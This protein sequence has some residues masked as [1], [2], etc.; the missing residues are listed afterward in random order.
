M[1]NIIISILLLLPLSCFACRVS[2]YGNTEI[3]KKANAV[4]EGLVV[5]VEL[6]YYQEHLKAKY[7]TEDYEA[8]GFPVLIMDTTPEHIVSVY[9][10][11]ILEG[12]IKP[13]STVK[14]KLGGCGVPE[15]KLRQTAIFYLQSDNNYALPQYTN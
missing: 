10:L 12:D 15:A 8:G 7:N 11:K 13:N 9:V 1:K 3:K 5:G 6:T 2:I 4:F 14:I